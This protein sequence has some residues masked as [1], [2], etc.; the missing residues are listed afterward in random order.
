MLTTVTTDAIP[1]RARTKM[2]LLAALL[3]GAALSGCGGTDT[4]SPGA[5]PTSAATDPTDPP[6]PPPGG[7]VGSGDAVSCASDADVVSAVGATVVLDP[8]S[9]D[10]DGCQYYSED[11]IVSVGVVFED[12]TT[13]TIEDV[14]RNLEVDRVEGVGDS[15]YEAV[16]P[17]GI[18]QFGVFADGRHVLVTIQGTEPDPAAARA[19][20]ALF[21]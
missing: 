6:E 19:V 10:E 17:G 21:A 9:G 16:M 13:R 12:P 11:G 2:V 1:R 20:Y 4:A 3:A 8:G 5:S 15:A 18:V 7:D 14:E